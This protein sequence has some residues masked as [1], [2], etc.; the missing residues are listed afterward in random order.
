MNQRALLIC[1]LAFGA[2][3]FG[4]RSADVTLITGYDGPPVPQPVAVY[5]YDFETDETVIHLSDED[6]SPQKIAQQASR[7]LSKIIEK[8]MRDNKIVVVRQSGPFQVPEGGL[9]IHGDLLKLDEGSRAK[10]VFI[11]FGYGATQ[12]D[13]RARVYMRG[14]SGPEKIAEYEITSASGPKPGVLT[15]LPIGM[16]IQG[17][18]LLVFGINAATAT[19]GEVNSTVAGDVEET[20]EEWVDALVDFFR[21]QG[22][23]D[24]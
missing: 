11:G 18:S 14:S 6:R 13:T 1:M 19:L 15:T 23:V 2:T 24:E 9:A 21:K 12:L 7:G 3:S 17:V 16:A 10:R 20:G 8:E 4:C 5:L 22:W